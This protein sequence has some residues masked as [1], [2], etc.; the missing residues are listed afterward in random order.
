[1]GPRRIVSLVL[2]LAVSAPACGGGG[3]DQPMP[4]AAPAADDPAYSVSG[5]RNWYL[6]GNGL[7]PGNDAVDLRVT[8]PEGTTGVDAWI[9]GDG[10]YALNAGGADF[11]GPIDVSALPAGDHQLLLALPDAEIAFAS[12]QIRRSHPF[13]LFVSTDWDDS[14]NRPLSLQLQEELHATFPQ[15]KLTHFVGPYT[16]TDPAVSEQRRGELVDWVKM[17]RTTYGDEIGLHIHPYCNFVDTTTV[18]CHTEPSTVYDAGDAT[19]YT[20]EVSSYT[21]EE[22]TTILQ[23][24]DDLFTTYGLDKPTAF[25]AGGWTAD[26]G[27]LQALANDGFVVDGSANNWARMEEWMG[28]QNGVLYTWNMEHWATIND[29]S[30]PYYPSSDDILQPGEPSSGVL[31]V[32]DNGILVDYVTANEML[33]IFNA[34]WSGG[35][36]AEPKVLS[37][38]YHPP[39]FSSIY[40]TTLTTVL[41]R[42]EQHLAANDEGPVVYATASQLTKVWTR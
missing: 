34:N 11:V 21:T 12:R 27:T 29:T 15:M 25:R 24:A 33:D 31:E 17:M 9:D 18:P 22:F 19:G 35:A 4:P 20:V 36:L 39:N 7:T 41:S 40:K 14:D 23:A 10:P 1:M 5:L 3:D 2:L 30:Q 38:G 26:E 6:V 28:Q 13:Y 37:I 8:A 16:F 32:P 42:V